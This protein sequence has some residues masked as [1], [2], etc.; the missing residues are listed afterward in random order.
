M[1]R[2]SFTEKDP[3]VPNDHTQV[4][5]TSGISAELI[6][7]RMSSKFVEFRAPRQGNDASGRM[8]ITSVV[9]TLNGISDA[10]FGVYQNVGSAKELW[11]QLESKYMVEDASSKKYL[12][13]NFNNYKMIDS[14]AEESGKGKG[15]EIAGSSLVNMIED[16]KNKN[17]KKNSKG[18]KRKNNGQGSKDPNSSQGLNFDFDV[19][20]FNHYVSHISEICYVQ[21]DAFAWWIESGATYH[22]YQIDE[23][24]TTRRSKRARVAKSFGYDFQ[25]Y[26]VEGSRDE[27]GPQYSYCYSIEV[28][29]RTF[30]KAMQSRCKP[31]GSK[32]IFKRKMKVD[33]TIDKF[34]ARLVIQ[35]F[36]QKE[37]ID[38]FDTYDPVAQISTIRLLI[39]LVATYN[40]VI[41]QMDVKTAFLNGHGEADV[42]LGI[43]I[44]RE[45]KGI[46]I[47]QSHYIEKILKKFKCDDC[48]SVSTPMDLTIKLMP[49]TGRAVDQLEYFKAIG[50]LMYAMTSTR[51]YIAYVAVLEGY[52]N[53]SWITN[54]EDHTSTTGWVFLLG[55]GAISWASKKQ[56]CTTDSTIEAEF[57]ALVATG[58][59]AEWLRKLI[60]EIPLWPKPIY[61][62]SIHC[63][64][65]AT[66]AKAYCQIYNGKSIHLGVRNSMEQE[67]T[68]QI[69][70]TRLRLSG[71]MIKGELGVSFTL[72]TLILSLMDSMD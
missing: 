9:D 29:P 33:G 64:S 25:L 22:A 16:G 5:S 4:S 14:R 8:M 66:L 52:Y 11:D 27:I 68:S 28:D 39:A 43:R 58:K 71:S 48:C 7:T 36:K 31:L 61:P 55:G 15:K 34:K 49:N 13:S 41:H 47:T 54:S 19:I 30:D 45:D 56:T 50:C 46:T 6:S 21:D 51:P 32:W 38:Y 63:D 57:V 26:V 62:I 53:A 69:L 70:P 1:H 20:P 44:K 18:K 42:I 67:I 2:A 24:P 37:G 17:N 12:V 3:S 72:K 35:G 40:L 65:A 10:L 23:T 60:Y 59:E